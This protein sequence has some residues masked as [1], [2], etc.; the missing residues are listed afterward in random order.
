MSG[1]LTVGHPDEAKPIGHT[2][3]EEYMEA[4]QVNCNEY[5]VSGVAQGQGQWDIL[6]IRK[7]IGLEWSVYRVMIMEDAQIFL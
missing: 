4:L 2:N 1:C 7:G 3:D 6:G 5:Q